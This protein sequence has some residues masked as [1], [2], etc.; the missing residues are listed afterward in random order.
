VPA[1]VPVSVMAAGENESPTG[2]SNVTPKRTVSESS[3]LGSTMAITAVGGVISSVR[4]VPGAPGSVSTPSPFRATARNAY[5]VFS[6]SPVTVTAPQ[7][8]AVCTNASLSSVP[9]ACTQPLPP[10]AGSI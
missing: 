10:A 5:S 9:S 4:P 3:G 6:A 8:P 1:S 2:S 7:A